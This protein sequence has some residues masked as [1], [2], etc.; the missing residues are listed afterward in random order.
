MIGLGIERVTSVGL[1][2]AL[3]GGYEE[4][5]WLDCVWIQTVDMGSYEGW[6]GFALDSGQVWQRGLWC[7][8]RIWIGAVRDWI[9]VSGVICFVILT[10]F[11][12]VFW[13]FLYD[14]LNSSFTTSWSEAVGLACQ[15]VN[16]VPKCQ[17]PR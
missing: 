17:V 16:G 1:S 12:N 4:L 7:F 15:S 3:S 8:I 9:W 13:Y 6:I 5:Q 11:C 2:L 10:L 14:R